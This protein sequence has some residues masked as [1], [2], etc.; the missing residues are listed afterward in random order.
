MTEIYNNNDIISRSLKTVEFDK[1]LNMLAEYAVTEKATQKLLSL[2]PLQSSDE[3]QRR[4]DETTAARAILD[5]LGNPPIASVSGAEAC[6]ASA[7]KEGLLSAEELE[8]VRKFLISCREMKRYLK[9]GE[10]TEGVNVAVYGGSIDELEHLRTEIDTVIVNGKVHDNASPEL[11]DITR[12]IESTTARIKQRMEEMLHKDR[13]KYSENF[14][15]MRG[16]RLTLPVKKEYKNSVRGSVIEISGTGATVFIEP[17][18]AVK[19]RAELESLE[20]D[21]ENEIRRILYTLTAQISDCAPNLR[22]NIEAMETLDFI[23]AKAKLSAHMRAIPVPMT[24]ERKII[25]KNGRHP[26]IAADKAVPLNFKLGGDCRGVV[27]TGPNTGGKTVAL[28]TVG[29]FSVMAQCGLHVPA[30]SGTVIAMHDKVLCDIGDGQSI[31]ENLSTFSAHIRSINDIL[32]EV[33]PY[34]LVLLDE[35][36][37]GTDPAEGMGIAIATLEELR[38]KGCNLAATTHYPEVKEY[39]ARAEGLINARMAFD[40]ETLSP[41][42]KLEIGEA[43]ESCALYIARRLGFPPHLLDIAARQAY[44]NRTAAHEYIPVEYG[45]SDTDSSSATPEFAARKVQK[46]KAAEKFQMGDSVMVYPQ[47]KIGIVYRPADDEGLVTV[48]IEG[49]KKKIGHKRLKLKAKAADL[50][51]PDYDFSIIFDSV[52]TRKARHTMG[53]KHVD[54]LSITVDEDM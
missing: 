28:K 1:I 20:I 49:K 21:K 54:G 33:T 13:S 32:A 4:T 22:L 36:G 16:G 7:E 8:S 9:R 29:I 30:E 53:R 2:T 39:A 11:K 6:I 48:Q 35:L 47:K 14:I 3:L 31:S 25:I 41:L 34:S 27:I 46:S 19:M 26:F 51:P 15:A 42:Y 24:S 44:G 45:G 10:A 12:K 50:Y 40:R 52:A 38:R 43:G 23:F 18:C 5:C 17:E 37:S